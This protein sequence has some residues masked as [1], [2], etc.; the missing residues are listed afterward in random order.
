LR[1]SYYLVEII[2][3]GISEGLGEVVG[4]EDKVAGALD[5]AEKGDRQQ[6]IERRC[7]SA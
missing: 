2:A 6:N 1:L 5:G 4:F 7:V 3:I